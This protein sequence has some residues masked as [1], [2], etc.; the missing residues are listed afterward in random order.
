MAAVPLPL[1]FHKPISST[2]SNDIIACFFSAG[3]TSAD[4]WASTEQKHSD[5][6]DA[7]GLSTRPHRDVSRVRRRVPQDHGQIHGQDKSFGRRSWQCK[8]KNSWNLY[9]SIKIDS[10]LIVRDSSVVLTDS[11]LWLAQSLTRFLCNKRTRVFCE[12][13]FLGVFK[14]GLVLFSLNNFWRI[15]FF[16]IFI[17]LLCS[18]SWYHLCSSS[19]AM[20]SSNIV[21]EPSEFVWT[22]PDLH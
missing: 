16:L 10:N 19:K 4:T 17:I 21:S 1:W 13:L 8:G 20:L 7:S 22:F 15:L 6:L 5:W 11:F 14:R 3:S 9:L 12:S 18:L 2:P